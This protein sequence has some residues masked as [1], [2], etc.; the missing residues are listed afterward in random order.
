ME[1]Y[2]TVMCPKCRIR[3]YNAF[4][5]TPNT[6]REYATCVRCK[7]RYAIDYGNGRVKIAKA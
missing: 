1:Q 5:A 2:K 3:L 4:V 7:I 6:H